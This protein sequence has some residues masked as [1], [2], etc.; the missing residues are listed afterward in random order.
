[1]EVSISVCVNRKLGVLTF[2]PGLSRLAG[3]FQPFIKKDLTLGREIERVEHLPE[4]DGKVKL[5]WKKK[6]TDTTF[7]E[8]TY[9]Y[10][11]ISAPFPVVRRWRLPREYNSCS[12]NG[13]NEAAWI[14]PF[15]HP[16]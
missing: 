6:Y 8:A 13:L 10:A 7:Q 9:D 4:G 5:L 16:S 14:P 12:W 15:L 2:I 11:V 3:A 1:M